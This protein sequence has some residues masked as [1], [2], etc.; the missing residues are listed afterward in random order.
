MYIKNIYNTIIFHQVNLYFDEY[1]SS[2]LTIYNSFNT[3]SIPMYIYE[4]I[5]Q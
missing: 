2:G 3:S 4:L 1:S 5:N